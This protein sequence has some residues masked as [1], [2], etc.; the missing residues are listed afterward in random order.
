MAPV[1]PSSTRSTRPNASMSLSRL[2]KRADETLPT[3][4]R[5]SLK[6]VEP[7]Q[8]SVRIWIVQRGS[9]NSQACE[10]GQTSP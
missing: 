2:D 6:R 3:P 7:F 10:I 4:L 5:M 1:A 8:S 9:R